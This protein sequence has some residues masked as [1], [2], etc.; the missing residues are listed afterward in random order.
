MTTTTA[1]GLFMPSAILQFTKQMQ[2]LEQ[3]VAQ[4]FAP[5]KNASDAMKNAS[6][7]MQSALA[8]M[9]N[10]SDAMQ[11]ALSPLHGVGKVLQNKVAELTRAHVYLV[12]Q[13]QKSARAKAKKAHAH[14]VA[15]CQSVAI[16]ARSCMSLHD[17]AALYYKHK[18]H[19]MR[20][21]LRKV[22]SEQHCAN[23]PNGAQVF[24]IHTHPKVADT[25]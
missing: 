8:P 10:A 14:L 7:A 3:Q 17:I 2:A 9:K 15:I 19:D 22:L 16:K 1:P 12:E 13:Y 25:N 5:M 4:Q 24:A 20:A 6:D 23:A 21:S 11:S 18:P